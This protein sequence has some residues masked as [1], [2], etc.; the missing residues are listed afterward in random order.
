MRSSVAW[1]LDSPS[2][3]ISVVVVLNEKGHLGYRVNYGDT[4]IITDSALMLDLRPGGALVGPL[5][6]LDKQESTKADPFTILVGKAASDDNVYVEMVLRLRETEHLHRH[7]VVTFRVYDDGLAFQYMLPEQGAIE[8]FDLVAERSEFHFAGDFKCWATTY[9]HFRSSFESEFEPRKISELRPG[10]LIG[11]PLTIEIDGGPAVA[12]TEANLT[13]YAGMYLEGLE[14]EGT[15][16][17]SRLAPLAS[18]HY[19]AVAT[20][21]PLTTPWRVIQIAPTP[22]KLIESNILLRLNAPCQWDDVS[23][24][25]PGKVAWDWWC[26]HTAPN[27]QID[28]V[29][30]TNNVT[31]RY[32]IDFAATMKLD[33][34][35][36]DGGWYGEDMEHGDAAK[37]VP[38]IDLPALVTYAKSKGVAMM[39]WVHYKSTI[40]QLERLF[41]YYE[42]VGISGVKVDFFDRDDQEIVLYIQHLLECAATHKLVVDLHGIY[43]P[44]GIER[45]YPNLLSHEG[46]LGAEYN[47]WSRRV[48]PEHNVTIPFTRMLAGPMDYTP[49]GFNNQG[50]QDFTPRNDMPMVPGTRANELAKYVVYQSGLQMV[51]DDPDSIIAQPGSDFLK[52]VPTTWDAT[53]GVDGKIGEFIAVARRKGDN[54]FL[55]V[56]TNSVARSCPLKLDFLAQ[57]VTYQA[58]I[59]ADGGKPKQLQVSQMAYAQGQVL[60]LELAPAGGAVVLFRPA[61]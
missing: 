30:G 21:T 5:E 34:F 18:G 42:S 36:L 37:S 41:A 4:P 45:T 39:V 25:K 6:L 23:W 13:N 2:S 8:I 51:S 1:Q 56:M 46:V 35:L 31:M 33:Y 60:T 16:L 53:V 19:A 52:I 28:F 58:T 15:A 10:A 29:G 49:G 12:I 27:R 61:T 44:T 59:F 54:W 43:K 7:L 22:A 26:G 11:L 38:K 20:T 48:T 14:G 47:K 55:G 57:G 9:P 24:I 50:V 40:G 32:F 17:V 3:A